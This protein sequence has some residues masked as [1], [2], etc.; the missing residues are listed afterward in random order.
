MKYYKDSANIVFAYEADGSQDHVIPADQTPITEAE[1]DELRKPVIT[2]FDMWERIKAERTLRKTGGVVVNIGGVDRWFH[3]DSDSRVQQLGLKDTARDLLADGGIMT[4]SLIIN[5]KLVNW[6]TMDGSFV[7]ITAK[8]AFD[9]V[10]AVCTLDAVQHLAAEVHKI[11]MEAS[12]D[13][14]SYD[15]STGWQSIYGE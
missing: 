12:S 4:D 10:A 1:A 8:V 15:Y 6:K 5:G 3:T 14:A 7:L 13:P 9:I 11:A 2:A